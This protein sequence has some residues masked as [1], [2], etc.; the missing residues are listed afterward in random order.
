LNT[1]LRI[2]ATTLITIIIISL[3]SDKGFAESS[4]KI[5]IKYKDETYIEVIEIESFKVKETVKRLRHDQNVEYVE[6]DEQ[7]FI[8]ESLVNDP[9]YIEQKE[10][11]SLLHIPEA[12]EQYQPKK[13]IVVAI[14]D[15][16]VDLDHPD[17]QSQLV[18]GINILEEDLP[19]QDTHGHGTHVAGLIGALTNNGVGVASAASKVNIMPIKVLDGKNGDL[20][21]LIKGI[22]FAIEQKVDI[23]N[24]SLGSYTNRQSLRDVI[25]LAY[26]NN[27]LVVSAVGNNSSTT[28][29]YPAYY[30]EVL[31]VA[32]TNET[33]SYKASFSNYGLTVDVA[34]P[35]VNVYSTW[36]DGYEYQSG[37]SM[38]TAIVTS[39]AAMI[40]QQEPWLSNDQVRQMIEETAMPVRSKYDLGLGSVNAEG[41][42][43]NIYNKNRIYGKNA[44]ETA[45]SISNAGW[46]QLN[47][48]SITINGTEVSEKFVIIASG[49]SFPDSLAASPLSTYLNS[50]ILLQRN[51]RLNEA[52]RNEINRLQPTAVIIVGGEFAISS[53]VE[54]EIK[55]LG[56]NVYRIAGEN[57]YETAV[58][59][60][61]LFPYDKKVSFI[62]SGENYPDVISV[63]S[64]AAKHSLPILYV[65]KKEISQ[66]VKQYILDYNVEKTYV[67]GG[68]RVIPE[69]IKNQLPNPTRI[70]GINRYE[71]C[72]EVINYFGLSDVDE[73]YFATGEDFRDA[74]SG[75]ALAG[76]NSSRIFLI[77]PEK[78]SSKSNIF[79]KFIKLANEH[80]IKKYKIIGGKEVIDIRKAW[81]IDTLL[82]SPE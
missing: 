75:S 39:I 4:E 68:E 74:L 44:I 32:S 34:A 48:K 58:K 81:S 6:H 28:V 77:H 79:N 66:E 54:E 7:I 25:T 26:E 60:S 76:K 30:D 67:I 51:K 41:A 45:I 8:A 61:E 16:G 62:V 29:I 13:E 18:E 2:I 47:L 10:L 38:S 3:F 70:S 37:T 42:L 15:T 36:L 71:T 24:L 9:Y 46:E 65:N 78:E 23:I 40:K 59:I 43:L 72:Y 31:A 82:Q 64:Y 14:I 20:S 5:L 50:P 35:G 1:P 73:I 27:I 80:N 49:K 63:A 21:T 57:R 55:S 56:L 69:L 11:F 33:N 17:L 12:W 22:E 52:N 53:S 19:P